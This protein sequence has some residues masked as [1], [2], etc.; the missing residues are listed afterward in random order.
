MEQTDGTQVRHHMSKALPLRPPLGADI[1]DDTGIDVDVV[2]VGSGAGGSTLAYALRH[3][4]A[5]ILVIERGDFI[6]AEPQNQSAEAV[7]VEQRYRT[8]EQWRTPLGETFVPR[9]YYCVG[10]STKFYAGHLCRFRESDFL[11]VEHQGG[12]SPEWP[13]TYRELEPYYSLAEEIYQVRGTQ[14]RDSTDPPRRRPYPFPQVPHEPYVAELEERMLDLGLHPN[15]MPL[16]VALGSGGGCVRC[17]SCDGFPCQYGAKGDAESRALQPALDSGSVQLLTR[18]TVLY[19]E[20]DSSG[21]TVTRAVAQR[22]DGQILQ[23]RAG[24]FVLSAGA[25]NSAALL[26]RS[27]SSAHP[28]GLS[29]RSGLVGR[30]YMVH[31]ISRLLAVDRARR[32][33]VVFQK[34]LSLNDFYLHGPGYDYPMGNIQLTGNL[35]PAMVDDV[36]P[37]EPVARLLEL[38]DYSVGWLAMSE[39]LPVSSNRVSVDRSGGV[40]LDWTPNNV[41]SH[42][43][44]VE[45]AR[46]MLTDMGF[47]QIGVKRAAIT[48]NSHQCGTVV[49]G[50]DSA[51]SVLD[52][53]CRSHEVRNLFVIDGSFFPSSA[54]MNPAL[55]IIAQAL[56]VADKGSVLP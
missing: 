51:R 56:R 28:K 44:L 22:A 21:R 31:N 15:P 3:S 24:T 32:N 16:A 25:V 10:G 42:S 45:Q 48:S 50:D 6:P 37:G 54:A 43:R 2:I 40:V 36:V 9:I 46:E 33:S 55:T 8:V 23:V 27:G 29:N 1:N 34:T 41:V 17:G 30:R 49:M 7:F 19:L 11:Q 12:T 18:T 38:T 47:H 5:Q 35:H 52:P 4:G 39:D 14:G 53:Y 20:T 26:L 13:F